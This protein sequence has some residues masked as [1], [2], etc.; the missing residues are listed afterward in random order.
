MLQIR[1][2]STPNPN[3]RKYVLSKDL[4]ESD[5]ITFK[6]SEECPHVPLASA[7]FD[8]SHVKQVHFFENILTIS[9][10]GGGEW[11]TIDQKVQDVL[12][13]MIE[14]HDVNFQDPIEVMREKRRANMDPELLRIDNILD[15]TIR[16]ALQA[17]GGDIELVEFDG[18][19]LSVRYMGACGDCPSSMYGTLEA[20]KNTIRHEYRPD[21][22]IV[23]VD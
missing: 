18:V 2:Q 4:K 20:I 23:I 11:S 21:I 5:R 8:I 3:A 15:H 14:D 1:I 17:D 12:H 16:P 7:L 13:E 22:D 10:S 6:N 9:Q 19:I